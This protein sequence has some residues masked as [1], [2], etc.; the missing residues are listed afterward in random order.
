MSA[1]TAERVEPQAPPA[2][3]DP[4]LAVPARLPVRHLSVSSIRTFEMCGE[5]WRRRYLLREKE[6][7]GAAVYAGRAYGSA[8]E[9]HFHALINGEQ[10]SATDADDLML[11][12]F[13]VEI[14][15]A[16]ASGELASGE[17]LDKVRENCR[18]PL[19]GYLRDI[20]P[21]IENPLAVEREMR[22]RFAGA[23]WDFVGYLDLDTN[24]AV[25]DHKL[26][27]SNKWSQRKVDADLQATS[28][29]LMKRLAGEPVERFEFHV[30][31]P[32]KEEIKVLQTTRTDAELEH[33]QRRIALAARQISR[34]AETG[35]WSYAEEGHWKCGPKFCSAWSGC[36]GGGALRGF[37]NQTTNNKEA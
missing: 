25:I 4:A 24:S 32:G 11:E 29:L 26:S 16:R 34:A 12:E 18:A 6:Q 36:P 2:A 33:M 31:K 20:A 13:G 23:E 37:G 35:D 21:T 7:M 14:A 8:L 27:G 28:Y 17:D 19:R 22:A 10:F 1:A 9:A 30:A 3:P 15:D 5:S